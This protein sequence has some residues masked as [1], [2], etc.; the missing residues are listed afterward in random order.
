M[1]S[2]NS[3]LATRLA[4]RPGGGDFSSDS[5]GNEIDIQANWSFKHGLGLGAGLAFFN[6]GSAAREIL[7]VDDNGSWGWI[8][9]S[10]KY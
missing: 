9:V 2:T 4:G 6:G 3:D 8:Q 10:W 5:L 7:S 1:P